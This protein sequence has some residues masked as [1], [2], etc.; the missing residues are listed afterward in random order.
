M[1][2]LSALGRS[3]RRLGGLAAAGA[4]AAAVT[5][6]GGAAAQASTF[7]RVTLSDQNGHWTANGAGFAAGRSD[8]Q[9]WVMDVGTWSTVE[10][11]SGIYTTI[12][13]GGPSQLVQLVQGGGF[14]VSG[15]QHYVPPAGIFG[16]GTV[17]YHPLLCGTSYQAVAYDPA[18]GYVY[19]NVLQEPACSVIH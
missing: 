3:R 15:A 1:R 13:N 12:V 17:N 8:V 11:Q 18:D 2:H 10:Y 14:V 19:G 4:V 6:G 16:G 9:L 5:L 7:S